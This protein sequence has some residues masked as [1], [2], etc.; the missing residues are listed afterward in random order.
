MSLLARKLRLLATRAIVRVIDPAAML[1]ALQ[2]EALADE[3]LDDVEHLEPYGH[4]AHPHPGAEAVVLNLG[5][6]RSGAVV[7][8]VA[9]RR[10]R[11]KGLAAGE[12]ALYDDLGQKV[13]LTRAGIVVD[14]AGL[15]VIVT[16][17]PGVTLDTPTTHMTGNLNVDGSIVAQGDISDHGSKS[18][19]GMRATYNGHTHP[20]TGSTTGTPSGGM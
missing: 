8:A 19:A 16:N 7:I 10:Y 12:V 6:N 1:Q 11:L 20:E 13:H 14:G 5:G 4:T 18:M 17:T 2:V 15:P 9:D 3:L